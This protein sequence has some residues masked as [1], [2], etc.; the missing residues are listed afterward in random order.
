MGEIADTLD[1]L[2]HPHGV[3]I[4]LQ[5]RHLCTQMR[6]VREVSPQTRTTF[7]RGSYAERPDLRAEFLAAAGLAT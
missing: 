1:E 4:F 6:G 7:W 2:L 3:A 5:A